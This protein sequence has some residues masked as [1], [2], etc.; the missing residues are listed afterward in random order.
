MTD[1]TQERR[2]APIRY[3]AAPEVKQ[4]HRA[5]WALGDYPAVATDIV[6]PLGPVLVDACRVA[7]GDRVLD[8]AAGTGNVAIPAAAG[9]R[10]RSRHRDLTPGAAR[11]RARPRPARAASTSRGRRGTPRRCP[12]PTARSTWPCR[13]SG[14]MFA[15]FHQAAADELVR[16]TRPGGRIGLVSWTPEGFIGQMFA[17]MKPVRPTAAARRA[18]AAAVGRR[19]PRAR[20]ARR[21]GRRRRGHPAR[22]PRGR[23]VR[24][25]WRSS[26]TTSRRTTA[27]RS[28]STGR[29]ADDPDAGRRAGCRA[30]RPRRPA[31]R[32]RRH[33]LGVPAAHRPSPLTRPPRMPYRSLVG[34]PGIRGG[35]RP[36]PTA[37][38]TRGCRCGSLRSAT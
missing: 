38:L 30:R 11:R 31:P 28:R 34:R 16:V 9:R 15:P 21:P 3:G 18:A 37:R 24:R 35:R 26:A 1:T 19:G 8:V 20:P 29:I 23:P 6:A 33:G 4:K 17:T 13:A 5:M 36:A 25:R 27:R 12:T 32:R 7:P 10:R 22:P 2:T 14:V